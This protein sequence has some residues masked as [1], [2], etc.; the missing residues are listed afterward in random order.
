MKEIREGLLSS[1]K[2]RHPDHFWETCTNCGLTPARELIQTNKPRER[3]G[4]EG[5]MSGVGNCVAKHDLW[6]PVSLAREKFNISPDHNVQCC[7]QCFLI[8][9]YP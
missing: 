2:C 1:L 6:G 7:V 4:E 8:Q 3:E 5:G 9:D